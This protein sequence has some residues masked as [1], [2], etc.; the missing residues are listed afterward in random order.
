M[1]TPP[2]LE[3]FAPPYTDGFARA[4]LMLGILSITCFSIFAGLPALICGSVA[5]YRIGR[6][7]GTLTGQGQ[8]IAGLVMGGISLAALPLMICLHAASIPATRAKAQEAHCQNNVRLYT[9]ACKRYAQEHD[10]TLPRLLNDTKKYI[11]NQADARKALHCP[12]DLAANI[13]YELV[14][15]GQP[16]DQLGDPTTTVIVREVHGNHHGKHA[17]G[18]ADGHVAME[19]LGLT[20]SKDWKRER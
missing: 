14:H 17:L 20:F 10:G 15:P 19:S 7:Y 16:L 12:Q 11:V 3:Q 18:Y 1:P 8:A 4:S 9:M 6:A 13:S 5:L 2:P